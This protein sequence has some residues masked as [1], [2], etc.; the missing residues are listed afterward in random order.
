MPHETNQNPEQIS[1]DLIDKHLIACGW[2]VQS[3][4]KINL[5][6][7]LGVAV[8]EY[9]TD[10]GPADYVLFVDKKPVGVIEAKKED[11]G[12]HLTQVEDQSSDYA[13]AKLKYLNNDPLP[14]VYESTGELTRFTDYRDLK[15]RSRP[16]FSFHKPETLRDLL[17]TDTLRNSLQTIRHLPTEGLR[18]CQITAITNLEESFKKNQPRSLIQMATGSGKTFTAITFIYRLLKYTNAKRILFI[19]DT[20][21]LGEQ[22]EQEF[23][24]F[25]PNDDNRKF[26]E[27]YG[28]HRLK[29]SFIPTDNQVYISTIQRLYSVLRGRELDESS[30]ET[31]P[32]EFL[33]QPKE[34]QAVEYN[35]KLPIEFFDFVVIDECHRSI[36]NLWKQV[37]EYFDAF[38]IGLTA[39]PDNRTFGYFNQNV[40]SEY[41]HEQAVIDGVNVGFNNY[42]IETEVT[43]ARCDSL[44]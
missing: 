40:V 42:L 12:L 35:P 10:V 3:K 4:K 43:Q 5:G 44:R 26:T 1:R 34:P 14:F 20:K 9:Q 32:N 17:K 39:T 11:E 27:L 29:S 41:K 19:V 37:L 13:K 24:A 16:I 22:A 36:Y 30:E 6:E 15:P 2:S 38:Q 33:W 18:D 25:L 21:N 23:M 31:N 28:V 8:R 7:S